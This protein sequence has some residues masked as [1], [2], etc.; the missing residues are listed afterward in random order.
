MSA[1]GTK[2]TCL[3]ALQMSAFGPKADITKLPALKFFRPSE[4]T[5]ISRLLASADCSYKVRVAHAPKISAIRFE[6][7]GPTIGPEG[8]FSPANSGAGCGAHIADLDTDLDPPSA[9]SVRLRESPRADAR[10]RGP[11]AQSAAGRVL[12]TELGG[13]PQSGDGR[14]RAV[15]RPVRER[16]PCRTDFSCR[17][18]RAHHIG[19]RDAQSGAGRPIFRAAIAGNPA[20]LQL[21]LPGR[22]D[23][24]HIRDRRR[25]MDACCLGQHKRACLADTFRTIDRIHRRLVFLPS[26]GA[27]YLRHRPSLRGNSAAV[28]AKVRSLAAQNCRVCSERPAISCRGAAALSKAPQCALSPRPPGSSVAS[29]T[30]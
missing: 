13:D 2:R 12:P 3:L 14:H 7:Q 18:V 25:F 21:R 5:D 30:D 19:R 28:A 17:N 27:R 8:F 29:S 22:P 11:V 4:I 15:A 16:L 9:A 20:T 1:F 10:D 6:R 24:L 23:E 26:V